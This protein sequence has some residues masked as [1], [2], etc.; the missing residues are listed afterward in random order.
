MLKSL[1]RENKEYTQL[2]HKNPVFLLIK[3]GVFM[4]KTKYVPLALFMAF[5]VKL[6]LL[7]DASMVD[8]SILLILAGIAA[9]YEF[10][11]N[12]RKLKELETKLDEVNKIFQT[13]ID[14]HSIEIRECKSYISGMKL[15]NQFK[16]AQGR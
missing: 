12:D 16:N 5:F 9:V 7:K 10:K 11:S 13:T 4:Y 6:L 1:F 15:Q 3:P 2:T 8:S 14:A